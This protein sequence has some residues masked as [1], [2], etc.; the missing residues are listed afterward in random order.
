MRSALATDCGSL[1][2]MKTLMDVTISYR[3]TI[4][5][6]NMINN[7][8]QAGIFLI[9]C[10]GARVGNNTVWAVNISWRFTGLPPSQNMLNKLIIPAPSC[11]TIPPLEAFPPTQNQLLRHGQ[12]ANNVVIKI[13]IAI[14]PQLWYGDSPKVSSSRSVLNN[15]FTFSFAYA[16][17]I[18]SAQNF[19]IQGNTLF[20]NASFITS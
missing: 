7:P 14:G 18:T 4:V 16:I 1:A 8:T 11:E 17:V 6:S 15:G 5:R 12:N 20:R 2:S 9:G 10:P 19:T 13:G 3:S